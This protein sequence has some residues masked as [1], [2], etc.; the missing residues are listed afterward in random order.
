MYLGFFG[1]V[2]EETQLK[3]TLTPLGRAIAACKR[4]ID[5]IEPRGDEEYIDRVHEEWELIEHLL[6]TSLVVCQVYKVYITAVVS[7]VVGLHALHKKHSPGT[8]ALTTT[9]STKR[10]ILKTLSPTIAP[11]SSTGPE[12]I[13][14][15]ADY[16]KHRDQWKSD[17]DKLGGRSRATAMAVM[18]A[19]ATRR[20]SDNLR[21]A[22]TIL[23]NAS[24]SRTGAFADT[25]VNWARRLESAYVAE[26]RSLRLIR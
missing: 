24:Y 14:A 1:L 2:P 8:T 5:G 7:R 3:R 25:L 9:D 13:D 17:W 11:T 26:L 18:A 16:F 12:L 6:G 19:G 4:L 20:K 22:A 21:T 15:F 23:G 10:A